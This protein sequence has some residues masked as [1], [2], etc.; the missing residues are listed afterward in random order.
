M[1][2]TIPLSVAIYDNPGILHWS[3]YI[4]ADNDADKTI[5]QILGARQR[6]F[7]NIKTSDARDVS[8][9]IEVLHLCRIDASKIESAK[10]I[11]YDTPIRN[12]VADWSCQDYVLAVLDRLEDGLV[13]DGRDS[14]YI[15]NKAV[16]AAKRES[17]L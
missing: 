2:S 1:S 15:R 14:D 4:E 7:P 17:W 3:L 5:I 10:N 13:I 11:A 9:L 6:Y 16:V 8:D 12:D